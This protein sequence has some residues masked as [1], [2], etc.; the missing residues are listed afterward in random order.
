MATCKRKTGKWQSCMRGRTKR[1]FVLFRQDGNPMQ[2]TRN[3]PRPQET[4]KTSQRG[5][6]VRRARAHVGGALERRIAPT[7]PPPVAAHR[8]R[9][10]AARSLRGSAAPEGTCSAE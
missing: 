8:R 3:E 1:T 7:A 5:H 6:A 4:E 2:A 10:R 9:R